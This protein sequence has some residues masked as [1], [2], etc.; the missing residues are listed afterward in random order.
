[1]SAT[2]IYGVV[3]GKAEAL[4]EVPPAKTEQPD[5]FS[6]DVYYM[7]PPVQSPCDSEGE[8]N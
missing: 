8:P 1:M 6:D 3:F 5:H 2:I 4:Q 7:S